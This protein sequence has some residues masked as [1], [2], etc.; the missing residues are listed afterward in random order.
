MNIRTTDGT[1]E[2]YN[3]EKVF[4]DIV[5]SYK[6]INEAVDEHLIRNVIESLFVYENMTSAEIRRLI[7]EALMSV[8][9]KVARAYIS[10]YDTIN[11]DKE[12]K[13]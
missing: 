10:K 11:S 6:S 4:N 7:E 8:N 9:K 1:L 13:R 3:V 12:Y 2:E 5:E